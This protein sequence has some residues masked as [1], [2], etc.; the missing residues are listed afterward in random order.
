MEQ[1]PNVDLSQ[2]LTGPVLLTLLA[3]AVGAAIRTLIRDRDEKRRL[4]D[5]QFQ[6]ACRQAYNSVQNR[7]KK[8]GKD[9]VGDK[10]EAGLAALDRFL[11]LARRR[12][13]TE[14]ERAEAQLIFEAIHGELCPG[15]TGTPP[16]PADVP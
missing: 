3:A 9:A 11:M 15:G 13:A 7:V 14:Q 2:G 6:R 10:E 1:L 8:H 16:P 4:A 5:A 12:P